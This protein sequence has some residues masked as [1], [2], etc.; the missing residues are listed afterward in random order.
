MLVTK[1]GELGRGDDLEWGLSNI[2]FGAWVIQHA[3]IE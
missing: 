2:Q 3:R 1:M